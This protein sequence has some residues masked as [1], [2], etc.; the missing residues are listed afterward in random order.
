[1]GTNGSPGATPRVVYVVGSGIDIASPVAAA[2]ASGGA[3]VAWIND[4]VGAPAVALPAG[5]IS[6]STRFDSRAAVAAA[7]AAA[8]EALGPPQQ[9]VL[10]VMPE[11]GVQPQDIVAASDAQW[12]AA[13]GQTMKTTLYVLQAAHGQFTAA[14]GGGSV[15]VIGGSFSLAGAAQLIP[16][17]TAIEGQRGLVKSAARQWGKTGITVNWIAAAA[18]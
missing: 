10:S 2:L 9:V 15:V 8:Q 3:R 12:H 18:K 7:F 13:C 6:V 16:F 14:S 17:S 11:A 1:M 4:G 5:V